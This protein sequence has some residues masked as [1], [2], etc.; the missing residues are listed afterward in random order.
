MLVWYK[1]SDITI[2]LRMLV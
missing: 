1:A 2:L